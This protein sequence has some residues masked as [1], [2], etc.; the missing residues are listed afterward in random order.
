MDFVDTEAAK[1]VGCNDRSER[2]KG[3]QIA[4]R[5]PK[6]SGRGRIADAFDARSG[7]RGRIDHRRVVLPRRRRPIPSTRSQWDLRTAAIKGEGGEVVFEQKECEVP[8]GW[9]Q[10]ATNVV[11]SKYF[12]G[13]IGTAERETSV[14]QLI[15]RVREPLPTGASRTAIS[16]RPRMASGSTAS[17]PGF[18]CTS[19]L[20]STR[21]S[22]STSGLYHAVRRPRGVV[23]LALGPDRAARSGSRRT[24][25]SIRRPRPASSRACRTTWRTSW[26]W[27]AARPCSSSSARGRGRTSPRCGRTARSFPAAGSRRG[28]CRSCGSTTRLRRWSRAA[29]RPA[30]RPR[31]SR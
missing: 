25:T 11:V 30:G 31:C 23:Q 4:G 18:A 13:E 6:S 1:N 17:C 10:L 20:R 28:R 24:P 27:P 2:S 15:H 16:P 8:A 19:T 26:S 9:S 3:P 12:Y 14:R 5:K 22:G 7:A 29:A 21:R